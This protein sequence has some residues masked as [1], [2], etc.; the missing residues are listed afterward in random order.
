MLTIIK[1]PFL[2]SKLTTLRDKKTS[3]VLFRRTMDEASYLI[4]SDVLKNI[5]I[6]NSIVQTPLKKTV[7]KKIKKKIV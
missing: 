3:N 4:A 2:Q 5:P 6:E 7:G 1:S